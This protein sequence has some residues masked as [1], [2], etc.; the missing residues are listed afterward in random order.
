MRPSFWHR[1]GIAREQRAR[2]IEIRPMAR[3]SMTGC[4]KNGTSAKDSSIHVS[5]EFDRRIVD[6]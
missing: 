4:Q 5:V 1:H 2:V 3:H 6:S